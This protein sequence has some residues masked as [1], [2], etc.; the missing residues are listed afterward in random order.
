MGL[1]LSEAKTKITHTLKA[2][3]KHAPG[4]FF[5]GFRIWHAETGRHHGVN[6][7]G[8]RKTYKLLIIPE[9]SKVLLHLKEMKAIIRQSLTSSQETLLNR[10]IPRVRGWCNYYKY[11]YSYCD[12][13]MW[14]M[15]ERW[16][17]GDI[18][19]KVRKSFINIEAETNDRFEYLESQR[20]GCQDMTKQ[21]LYVL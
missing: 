6:V 2:H 21:G 13:R 15:L 19:V 9:K 5:L 16:A 10:L 20:L 3:N 8:C 7:R 11:V 4:F 1:E 18:R 12:Y 14:V 17:K